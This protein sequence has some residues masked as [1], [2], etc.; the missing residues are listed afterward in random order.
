M[1][2]RTWRK[3]NSCCG[4]LLTHRIGMGFSAANVG[5]SADVSPQ[6]VVDDASCASVSSIS[7]ASYV[8][9]DL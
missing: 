3:D 8:R 6:D 4:Q 1:H 9:Y 7:T 2:K 5:Q